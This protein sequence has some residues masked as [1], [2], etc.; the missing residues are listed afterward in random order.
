MSDP[1]SLSWRQ[2]RKNFI[3]GAT[4]SGLWGLA[5]TF[6][7][8]AT[9][10]PMFLKKLGASDV[11]IGLI[12]TLVNLGFTFPSIFSAPIVERVKSVKRFV[13]TVTWLERSP[14]PFLSLLAFTLA[15]SNPQLTIYL[16]LIFLAIGYLGTGFIMP[17]WM[18]FVA[19]IIP[20]TSRGKFIALGN[21]LGGILGI[22][23]S[24]LVGRILS[25]YPFPQN[26]GICF[27]ITMF[28]L[29]VAYV[30]LLCIKE[31]HIEEKREDKKVSYM[32]EIPRIL[33]DN[34][35]FRN[36]I[37]ARFF[38][39][40]GVM[41]LAFYTVHAVGKFSLS[42]RFIGT[43]TMFF[44]GAQP[45][46]N[47]LWGPLADKT[48]HKNVLLGGVTC[49]LIG[50]LIALISPIAT[51]FYL[52]F[53]LSGAMNSAFMISGLP[54]ILEFAPPDRRPTFIGINNVLISPALALS[55]LIGGFIAKSSGYPTV[56][57]VSLIANIIG[58]SVLY[59]GV[60]DPRKK[61]LYL[62]TQ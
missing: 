24:I 18:D 5:L 49:N 26:F 48:G 34:T 54:I 40:F 39:S 2:Y 6:A 14:Y 8:T 55:P 53:A 27:L 51:P 32:K 44:V 28:I 15:K 47:L 35:Y 22:G 23:G 1:E 50:N 42:D 10:I 13:I 61:N 38:V 46:A 33:R 31:P 25:I 60:T 3:L 17:G 57:L 58:L 20:V 7:S 41:G 36:Y 52:V 37:L 21:G 19:R 11:E 59:F 16:S 9:V 45:L 4:Q 62:L 30:I 43:F 29:L 12:P 56:F